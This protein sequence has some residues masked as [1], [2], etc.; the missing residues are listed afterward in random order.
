MSRTPPSPSLS[1]VAQDVRTALRLLSD[2]SEQVGRLVAATRPLA[3]RAEDFE[4]L[5][6]PSLEEAAM[7]VPQ[8]AAALGIGPEQTRRLLRA[9]TLA[10]VQLGGR[11]GWLVSKASVE[12]LGRMRSLSRVAE[13]ELA[14][15]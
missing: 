7:S 3:T 12:R 2:L 15:V 13:R 4:S 5:E 9:G 8:A 10:G 11:R 1:Q 6:V 14:G